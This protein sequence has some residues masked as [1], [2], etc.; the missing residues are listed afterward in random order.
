VDVEVLALPVIVGEEK[1]GYIGIYIDIT[2]LQEARR[3]AEAA[4]QAKSD[5]LANMSHELRTPLNA[6]LGFTQL[7]DRDPSLSTDQLEYLGIIDRSG[8]HLLALINDVLEMSKIEAGKVRLQERSFDLFH[9]LDGLEEI[10]GLRAQ[11][12]GLNLVFTH[13]ENVPQHVVTDEGKLGQVLG[14]LLGNAIK[15]TQEG[16][17]NL[18]LTAKPSKP[19]MK[20]L[21]FEVEDTGPGISPEELPEIFDAFVQ[22]QTG[23]DAHEGTGLGL[24]V[25]R[26]FVHLMGGDIGVTSQLGHGSCFQ[27]DVQVRIAPPEAADTWVTRPVRRVV[28]IESA[29]PTYRLLIAEDSETN[30][31]LLIKLLAPIGFEVRETGNGLE[32]IEAWER[33][34]PHLIWMDMR[35]PFM[36]GYEATRR[37]KATTDGQATIIIALTASAFEE[38]REKILAAGCDDFMRKPFREGEMF[39]LLTKHLGVRYTYEEVAPPLLPEVFGHPAR[40]EGDTELAERLAVLPVEWVTN[41][42]RAV[43][44][45]DLRLMLQLVDQIRA[46]DPDLAEALAALIH[47]FEHE[48]ILMLIEEARAEQ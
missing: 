30:R 40:Q 31:E 39:D 7:M 3:Q 24:T 6:I 33:W 17:V 28:G 42:Q 12:K 37:I 46:Q 27:F 11:R 10:F 2:D 41:L 20:I 5:F 14:N 38:D 45:G 9:Q 4:N 35:M 48:R 1:V 18:R 13:D 29:Q 26:Q 21:H 25:S 43:V 44:L 36:D 22:S 16:S 8:E 47:D 19:G 32:A 15:F 23:R 34:K